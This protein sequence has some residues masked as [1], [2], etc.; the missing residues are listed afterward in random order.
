M[1]LWIAG[2]AAAVIAGLVVS[3]LLPKATVKPLR[4]GP[5]S[6]GARLGKTAND[7]LADQPQARRSGKPS[8][9]KR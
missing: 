7:P 6:A 5:N 2:L 9:G 4:S 3:M 8:F 1:E